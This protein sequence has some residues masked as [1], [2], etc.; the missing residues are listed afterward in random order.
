MH[1]APHW[2][3]VETKRK[4]TK[5]VLLGVVVLDWLVY[6]LD[7]QVP[8]LIAAFGLATPTHPAFRN[9]KRHGTGSVV[10]RSERPQVVKQ[11]TKAFAVFAYKATVETNA[12][13]FFHQVHRMIIRTPN[14]E[15]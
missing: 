7:R 14:P 11:T 12:V 15:T 4:V 9:S 5:D 10:F 2:D 1:S 8:V 3:L 6:S 13:R